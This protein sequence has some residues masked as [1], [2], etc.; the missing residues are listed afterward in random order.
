MKP[1]DLIRKYQARVR[2]L[3]AEHADAYS[4]GGP[5]LGEDTIAA[6]KREI[7]ILEEL[8]VDLGKL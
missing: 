5:T 3:K 4:W 8:I 2:E 6:E 7:E 1:V